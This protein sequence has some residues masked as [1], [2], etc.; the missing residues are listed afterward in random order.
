MSQYAF[1][2]HYE[3]FEGLVARDT[4]CLH[5]NLASNSWWLPAI[6]LWQEEARS[7]QQDGRLVCLEWRGCGGSKGLKAGSALSLPELGADVNRVASTLGLR[8]AC[9]IAHSTGG[10][11]GLQAM[12]LAPALWSRALLLDTVC[13]TGVQFGPEM[14]A[15][16]T[17][18]S[19][20]RAFCETVMLG[21][22]Q[23]G[24]PP[25][26]LLQKIV[27]DAFQVDKAIWHGVPDLLRT[28][29]FRAELPKI[30]Q[31][32]LVLHGEKDA[33]ITKTD[34]EALAQALPHG[35][36][37]ALPGRGH[38]CNVEDPQLFVKIANEFLFAQRY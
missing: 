19:E 4:L 13:A 26:A 37:Q 1:P 24:N 2:L 30:S 34:S 5:G 33:L 6:S 12:R 36:F 35:R 20:S 3:I 11:I 18:M 23:G 22:I 17:Q 29:D 38:S 9:L 15:A 25:A 16:F 10:I 7:R 27:D 14:Y 31:P 8:E 28:L 32:T 21:T